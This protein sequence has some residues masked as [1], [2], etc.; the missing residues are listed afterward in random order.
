MLIPAKVGQRVK[1]KSFMLV[2]VKLLFFKGSKTSYFISHSYQFVW[3]HVVAARPQ[4]V[5]TNQC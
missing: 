3:N 1:M 2:S 4:T 5:F